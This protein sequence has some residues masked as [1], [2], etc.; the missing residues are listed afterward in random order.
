ML[1]RLLSI[2]YILMNKGTVTAKELAERFEV[3]TRTIYRDIE[4]LSMAGIPVYAQ[5]GKNGGI[6]LS[7]QFVLNKMLVTKEE[8]TQIL[9]ALTSLQ[10][11]GAGQEQDTL[12]KLGE[13]FH[14]DPV[15]WVSI[16]FSDWSGHRQQLFE[17][18]RDAILN[19]RV[20]VFDYYGTYGDMS[21][22]TVEPV[23]LL[24]KE[25][26]W[27]VRAYCRTRHAMRLFKVLR[28]KRVQI[29]EESFQPD[30]SR[31]D[32]ESDK[33]LLKNA[34]IL[35]DVGMQEE[36]VTVEMV[37]EKR[38][39]YRIYD[40]FAEEE[41]TVQPNG[42]FLIHMKC[43]PDDWNYGVVLSFGPSLKVVGPESFRREIADRIKK[44]NKIYQN[45]L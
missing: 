18:I 29:S 31:L 15:N 3:S 41:I 42:D 32:V 45:D 16:D 44:M 9:A 7:E 5:Q 21:H 13:F 33:D 24:F 30:E 11:T 12:M 4:N 36:P 20:L 37:I 17:Q 14:A 39:A 6:S 10:E 40:R 2:I 25:Y 35:K 22:R 43:F 23:Q 28:M 8:Q 1:N 19:H 26:T 38:E 27:Y 34:D